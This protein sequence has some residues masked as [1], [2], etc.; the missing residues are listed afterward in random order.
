MRR[1]TS[2]LFVTD[3]FEDDGWCNRVVIWPPFC[4]LKCVL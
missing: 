3:Q 4:V 1:M 2:T